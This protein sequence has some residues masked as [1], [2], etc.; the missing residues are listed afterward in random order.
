M[1]NNRDYLA[2][3]KAAKKI[4]KAKTMAKISGQTR[5]G[6]RSH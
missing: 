5:C 4:I 6:G 3:I 1:I 2:A